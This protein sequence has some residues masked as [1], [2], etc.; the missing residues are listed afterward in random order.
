MI[1]IATILLI[2]LF[3]FLIGVLVSVKG[4]NSIEDEDKD[5]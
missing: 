5:E 2:M 3:I 1:I 4:I